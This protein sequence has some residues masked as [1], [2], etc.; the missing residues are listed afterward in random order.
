M[1]NTET[2]RQKP[3]YP[4]PFLWVPSS[5][6][7]MG[8]IYVTVGAVANIMFLNMGLEVK[9]AALYASLLGFPYTFKFVWAPVLELY[10]T[11][12][13]FVVLMQFLIAA[14]IAATAFGLK[15]PGMTW[16]WPTIVLLALV[17]LLGAT[18]DIGSDGVYVTTLPPKDMAKF[19]GFQSMCWNAGYLVAA[20]PLIHISGV[21]H[22]GYS[23]LTVQEIASPPALVQKLEQKKDT[24]SIFVMGKF[25]E[26]ARDAARKQ[27]ATGSQKL[28]EAFVQSNLVAQLNDQSFLVQQLN[29][30]VQGESIFEKERFQ[31]VA[32]RPQTS[33][34][35]AQKL[36]GDE[37]ARLNRLLL[38]DAYPLDI[39][40][41]PVPRDWSSSWMIILL[42][43]AGVM[44][45]AGFYHGRMLP[46]GAAAVDAPKGFGDAMRTF[47]HAFSTFFQKQDVWKLIAF[48]FFYRFGFGLINN[49]GPAFMIDPR[50]KGG[51][52]LNNQMLGDINGTY[53]TAAFIVGSLIG[54][55]IVSRFS[56]KKT[57]LILCLCLNVP[58]VTFLILSQTLPTSYT[59]IATIVSLEKLGWG[60]G[61]V[62]HMIYM[63]Q[64]IAPGP[65]RTAHYTIAT[66]LMGACMMSMGAISG[67]LQ[68][69]V[70]YHWFFI[71]VLFAAVPSILVTIFAPFHNPDTTGRSD[72]DKPET[73][74][75]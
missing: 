30:V 12:K 49:I 64:Q 45:L 57:L 53:G 28:N 67:Y 25:E 14:A 69:W 72:D 34:L 60:I 7:A 13:F 39:V 23:T 6:L 50:A 5:Y 65:Y 33:S 15:L 42:I 32:L 56:L 22:A 20:G 37:L 70:G 46:P 4:N 40:R 26:A 66:A 29:T 38:E 35:I 47:G 31:N 16:L 41:N 51:L 21:L 19:T 10:K 17:G 3:S 54:G 62:G 52:G 59:V 73:A 55:W 71:I 27:L 24:V 18:Q 58:N 8:L 43:I 36:Q 44:L 2:C 63:M 11:K 74:A 1:S 75:A 68:S 61:C 48:A 9:T